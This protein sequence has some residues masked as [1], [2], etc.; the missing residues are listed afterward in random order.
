MTAYRI[1]TGL[2]VLGCLLYGAACVVPVSPGVPG[3][4]LLTL[5]F[6]FAPAAV[7]IEGVAVKY[8]CGV[9]LWLANPLA[10]VAMLQAY[11]R[12]YYA[13]AFLSFWA[14]ILAMAAV[15]VLPPVHLAGCLW[16]GSMVVLAVAHPV[17][18][19][20]IKKARR[21]DWRGEA[22]WTRPG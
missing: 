4:M 8:F 22:G 16:A 6:V 2:M 7:A 12:E 3:V 5:P 11:R 20:A 17:R 15:L 10:A 18:G 1:G 9:G 19:R 14:A 13:A 21:A